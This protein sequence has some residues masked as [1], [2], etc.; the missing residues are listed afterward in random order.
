IQAVQTV[1]FLQTMAGLKHTELLQIYF[2]LLGLGVADG[3]CTDDILAITS[4]QMALP[5]GILGL[6]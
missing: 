1:L 2:R 4:P 5:H 3:R 6:K